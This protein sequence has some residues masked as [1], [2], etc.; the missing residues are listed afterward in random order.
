MVGFTKDWV[1]I[2]FRI[3][4]IIG[5]AASV[6]TYARNSKRERAKWL[7]DL[8]Q[9]FYMGEEHKEIRELIESE[10]TAFASRQTD[11]ELLHK[12]DNFLNFFEFL[13]YLHER[14]I[15]AK[16][17]VDQLFGYPLARIFENAHIRE[18]VDTPEYGYEGVRHL[19][20]VLGYS[21]SHA[22]QV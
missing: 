12:L 7:F 22:A 4:A 13:Y 19:F 6:Y 11:P 10:K 14:G 15:L 18:Y 9:K 21:N 3:I 8:F 5:A 2:S 20:K 17:D 16:T 1:D